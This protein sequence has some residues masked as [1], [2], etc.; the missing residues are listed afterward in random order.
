ML[1]LVVFICLVG[2]SA[3]KN[4]NPAPKKSTVLKVYK[5]EIEK[6]QILQP[7]LDIVD[8]QALNSDIQVD[9]KYCT[10]DNFLHKKLYFKIKRAYL[11]KEVA[12]RLSKVQDQL[13]KDFPGHRLLIY[14]ALRPVAVQKLMWEALD[15]L[16]VAA[17]I[18]FVSNP[19]HLSLHNLGAAIDLTIIDPKG[20]PL[21]MGA[22]FDDIRRIAYPSLEQSFLASG[23]LSSKQLENRKILRRVMQG[24]GF[25]QL[26]TEWWHYNACSR[27]EAKRKYLVIQNE[28]DL[29]KIH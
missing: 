26:P 2:L 1:R 19:K 12:L 3:C 23:Q 24:Q 13:S 14:D 29:F 25:R 21:D 9:L 16:P 7:Q 11:Q 5:K 6:P 15:T 27:E 28:E 22:E 4:E 20:I 8:I 18:K 10:S 17:R